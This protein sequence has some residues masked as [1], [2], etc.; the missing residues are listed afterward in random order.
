M[1]GLAYANLERTGLLPF[2]AEIAHLVIL[3]ALT[4]LLGILLGL[5]K[6]Q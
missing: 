2:N 4:Y 3:M 5:R 6:Y 1:L